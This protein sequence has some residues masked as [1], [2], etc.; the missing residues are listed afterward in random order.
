MGF[1]YLGFYMKRFY[2]TTF[3]FLNGKNNPSVFKVLLINSKNTLCFDCFV[4]IFSPAKKPRRTI[5]SD[6]AFYVRTYNTGRAK[7]YVIRITHWKIPLET[8]SS[9]KTPWWTPRDV[10]FFLWNFHQIFEL[11]NDFFW[12]PS[13]NK[14]LFVKQEM[15]NYTSFLWPLMR[16]S[17][18][19]MT[20]FC[21]NKEE[22]TQW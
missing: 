2:Q 8:P 13:Q 10:K 5:S 9:F 4:A 16:K 12:F 7:A 1:P 14:V 21:R 15:V 6:I 17:Y 3:V 19:E 22:I 18:L 11:K 20:A